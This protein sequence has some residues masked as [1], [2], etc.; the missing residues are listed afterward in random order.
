VF[1]VCG[2]GALAARALLPAASRLEL[3]G[4]A[5]PLGG[6][7]LTFTAFLASWAGVPLTLASVGMLWALLLAAAAVA[8]RARGLKET[9]EPHAPRMEEAGGGGQNRRYGREWPVGGSLAVFVLMSLLAAVIAIGR[10][11]SSYDAAAMWIVKGYGIAQ[12]GSIFG[13]QVWGAHGLAYPLNLHLLVMLFRLASADR[14][15]GSQLIYL[16]FYG[17]TAIVVLGYWIRRQVAPVLCGLGLLLLGSVPVMLLHST[18]GFPNLPMAFYVVSGAIYGM[19]G[20]SGGR[21]GSPRLGGTLL[22]MGSWTI[23]E[24]FHYSAVVLLLVVLAAAWDSRLRLRECVPLAAP[25]FLI[26]GVWLVFYNRYG[27][28]GSQAIGAFNTMLADIKVGDY[29]LVELRLIFGYVRRY[30]FEVNT[31]GMLFSAG[32]VILLLGV[33]KLRDS[34]V[35]ES[36]TLLVLFA[37]TGALTCA[38]F[39]LRSFV[40]SD[41]LA[42]LIRGFPRGFLSSAIFFATAIVLAAPSAAVAEEAPT[43]DVI[44]RWVGEGR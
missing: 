43:P 21:E 17:S 42:W 35:P 6:G 13:A 34:L 9:E 29:N 37:G 33:V 30:L 7:L 39:Y 31:W 38:L 12:E 25:Y 36:F 4:L 8:R 15:P 44:E 41:F 10:A 26:T 32:G 24:G 1:A 40:T 18:V 3:F 23:I 14:I 27:A 11:H 2:L 19:E 22:G 28:S 5:F 20:L 16:L